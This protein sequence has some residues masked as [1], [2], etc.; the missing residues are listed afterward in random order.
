VNSP[1][2]GVAEV[3]GHAFEP[4]VVDLGRVL[5]KF[6]E[7]SNGIPDVWAGSDIC[8][9]K[10]AEELTIGEAHVSLERSMFGGVLRV[11]DGGIEGVNVG[12]RE[13]FLSRSPGGFHVHE[14]F[15][16]HERQG[17]V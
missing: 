3:F 1:R 7:G 6:G 16:S 15:P 8:V 17:V 10:F 12:R 9:E 13:W 4:T 11:S 14:E 5:G 2:D